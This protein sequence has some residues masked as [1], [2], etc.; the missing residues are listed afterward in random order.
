MADPIA[1]KIREVAINLPQWFVGIFA[2]VYLSGYLADFFYFSSIGIP[3]SGFD[4]LKLRHI[5]TGLFFYLIS[6]CVGGVAY[7]AS[8][9]RKDLD[10]DKFLGR[11]RFTYITA[12]IFQPSVVL[13]IAFVPSSS[14]REVS[15]RIAFGA[16]ILFNVLIYMWLI[17]RAERMKK[18]D[19]KKAKALLQKRSTRIAIFMIL[20][21]I[22][23]DLV[24]F[25]QSIWEFAKAAIHTPSVEAIQSIGPTLF[26]IFSI[27]FFVTLGRLMDRVPKLTDARADMEYALA[28]GFLL[29]G[30]F[31]LTLSAYAYA[32][33]PFIPVDRGGASFCNAS[34]VTAT[35]K[36]APDPVKGVVVY[37]TS[38][39][40]YI[41]NAQKPSDGCLWK[42]K[43]DFPSIVGIPKS[44]TSI[45]IAI[46]ATP[47]SELARNKTKRRLRD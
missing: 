36:G 47:A 1:P 16:L 12:A 30:T 25:G 21:S 3:E 28:M 37:T 17:N 43:P 4:V 20:V 46:A 38:D 8:Y 39:I 7:L 15:V 10:A 6:L 45:A 9:A 23:C 11:N 19:E 26:I 2:L 40:I 18:D 5:Q 22:V 32:V 14:F 35:E 34:I 41:A 44:D 27:S 29:L 31:Y 24:I 33:L 13:A 42:G